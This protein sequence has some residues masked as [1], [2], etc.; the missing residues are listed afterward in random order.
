MLIRVARQN[1][2]PVMTEIYNLAIETKH[3]TGDMQPLRVEDR[4]TWF[5]EHLP[6]Q[7]PIFVSE[8][9]GQVVGWCSLP[10][11]RRDQ[12]LHSLYT[13]PPRDRDRLDRACAGCLSGARDS[14]SLCDCLGRQSSQSAPAGQDG[15]CTMGLPAAGRRLRGT[16]SGA[17]VLRQA[18]VEVRACLKPPSMSSP[19]AV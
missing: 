17:P 13:P 19:G 2:L 9:D 18:C 11:Y 16:G 3:S 12:L 6:D 4:V 14:A 5:W 7:F 8:V 10:P 1:D 15:L